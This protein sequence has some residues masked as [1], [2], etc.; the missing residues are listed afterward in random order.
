MG[1]YGGYRMMD[2]GSG[3]MFMWIVS[4]ILIVAVFYAITQNAKSKVSGRESQEKPM[5][6]L[7]KRYA[8]GEITKD[9]FDKIKKDLEE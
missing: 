7:K 1:C 9:E 2:F 6:L 4:I 5:D 8:R 3:G